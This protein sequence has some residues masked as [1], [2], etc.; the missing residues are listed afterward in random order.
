MG[1]GNSI[2]ERE[3]ILRI[4]RH[5]SKSPS[6]VVLRWHVQLGAV[7]IPKAFSAGHQQE[8]LAVFD[9]ELSADEMD[10]INSLTQADGR[11]QNQD[12]AVYEEFKGEGG[13]PEQKK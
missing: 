2:T 7:P 13:F 12:P 4:A 3:E 1:R 6:Q 5:H 8:N 10:R 9:F 11:L